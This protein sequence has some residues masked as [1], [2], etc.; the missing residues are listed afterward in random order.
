[1]SWACEGTETESL[2]CEERRRIDVTRFSVTEGKS[3]VTLLYSNSNSKKN[4]SHVLSTNKWGFFL[5]LPVRLAEAQQRLLARRTRVSHRAVQ[6]RHPRRTIAAG[7]HL[8]YLASK[9][10]SSA[11]QPS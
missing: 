5:R 3:G 7:N 1:M 4:T 9:S 2:P 10:N 11:I 6:R 8:P